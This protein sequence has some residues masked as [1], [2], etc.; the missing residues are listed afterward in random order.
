MELVLWCSR[1][2][3]A[4]GHLLPRE[5]Q[6]LCPRSLSIALGRRGAETARPGSRPLNEKVK[7]AGLD[8]LP[9]WVRLGLCLFFFFLF[10]LFYLQETGPNPSST[11]Q[12]C[13]A[14]ASQHGVQGQEGLGP[15]DLLRF[16]LK[17]PPY[18][19]G[20]KQKR[21]LNVSASCNLKSQRGPVY[22]MALHLSSATP[23]LA[24]FSDRP[25]QVTWVNWFVLH[26]INRS[27]L[28]NWFNK[29]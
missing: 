12:R 14:Q 23:W 5:R 11:C 7:I 13:R 3:W 24:S 26:I 27:C 20:P 17:L 10:F 18:P 15:S 19:K 29:Y 2:V 1:A 16:H 9:L 8:F 21:V 6:T 4:G 28:L 25:S 22:S